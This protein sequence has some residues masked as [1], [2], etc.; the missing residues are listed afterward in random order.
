MNLR[1]DDVPAAAG[2][3]YESQLDGAGPQVLPPH[4]R[5][6]SLIFGD[7]LTRDGAFLMADPASD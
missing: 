2:L 6:R 4:V 3:P 1:L 5:C 7:Q